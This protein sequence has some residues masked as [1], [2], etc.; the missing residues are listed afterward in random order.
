VQIV[1]RA[2]G[3]GGWRAGVESDQLATGWRA[4]LVEELEDEEGEPEGVYLRRIANAL[5]AEMNEV[6]RTN[7]SCQTVRGNAE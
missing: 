2:D 7:P 1:W 6:V 5:A 4:Y 3:T